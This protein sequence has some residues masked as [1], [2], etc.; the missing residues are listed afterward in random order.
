M[1]I[2]RMLK[3]D[4]YFAFGIEAIKSA[5]LTEARVTE[6]MA[7]AL[8]V[9]AERL[10]DDGSG[11]IDPDLTILQLGKMIEAIDEAID[12]HQMILLATAHPGSLLKFYLRLQDY[13]LQH[14]GKVF[15][16]GQSLPAGPFLWMDSVQSVVVMS[17]MG[18]LLHTHDH[19]PM[20]VLLKTANQPIGLAISDHGFAGAAIN[21][22]IK[23]VA[24]H[25][26]DDPGIP[27][28]KDIGLNVIP[29]PMNDNQLNVRTE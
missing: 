21:R 26:V 10:E 6:I 28:A 27:V 18:S 12:L 16:L 17:D 9:D 29:V 24:L 1:A 7:K 25:D 14:H 20:E 4:P 22:G 2:R 13:I 15:N 8:G 3:F 23:T 19:E 11:Y 5:A